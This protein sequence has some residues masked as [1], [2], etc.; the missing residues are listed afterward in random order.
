MTTLKEAAT[1]RT[2]EEIYQ[3]ALRLSPEEREKLVAMLNQNYPQAAAAAK[4]D[5]AWAD[6]LRRRVD[7][8]RAG[9]M[10]TVSAGEAIQRARARLAAGRK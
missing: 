5:K 2:L 6:E 8:L 9:Q 3:D 10:A 4:I 7:L 1:P